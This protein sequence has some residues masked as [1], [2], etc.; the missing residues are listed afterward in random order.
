LLLARAVLA[1]LDDGDL[2]RKLGEHA[3]RD[4][5]ARFDRTAQ[6]TAYLDWYGTIIDH[7]KTHVR[8]DPKPA[9]DRAARPVGLALD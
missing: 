3:A 1:L 7:W 6:V 8:V 5:R 2:T 4:A 9:S